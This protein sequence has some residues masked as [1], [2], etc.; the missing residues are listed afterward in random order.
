MSKEHWYYNKNKTPKDW[1]LWFTIIVPTALSILGVAI[2]VI[3]YRNNEAII[4]LNKQVQSL[5]K[6]S[7]STQGI[8]DATSKLTVL[9]AKISALG[10]ALDTL[11]GSI[12]NES[13][14]LSTSYHS[15]I[16]TNEK[17]LSQQKSYVEKMNKVVDLSTL[18]VKEL[19]KN[20]ELIKNDFTRRVLFSITALIRKESDK[21]YMDSI[22]LINSGNI[23]CEIEHFYLTFSSS[24]FKLTST[25]NLFS[26]QFHYIDNN[27]YEMILDPTNKKLVKGLAKLLSSFYTTCY[28]NTSSPV[29]K[30]QL[31]YTNRYESNTIFG[32]SQIVVRE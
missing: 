16:S 7:N 4:A 5:N 19:E 2:S 23:E 32:S 10:V 13:K 28:F 29:I 17:M 3:S 14:K 26:I 11:T 9:P 1:V 30:Y 15:L 6:I 31:A 22:L 24:E 12:G 21:Y 18:Q 8:N 27:R 20:N 25:P